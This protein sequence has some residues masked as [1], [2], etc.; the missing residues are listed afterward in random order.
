MELKEKIT[1]LN[2]WLKKTYVARC[3]G[4]APSTYGNKLVNNIISNSKSTYICSRFNDADASRL[5][6]W[7]PRLADELSTIHIEWSDDRNKVIDQIRSLKPMF[8]LH[9]ISEQY[10]GM[11]RRKFL[12]RCVKHSDK[13]AN[14][15]F[16]Q[17]DIDRINAAI[18]DF[19]TIVSGMIAQ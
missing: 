5:E 10:V 4:M 13:F 14:S 16:N 15:S 7:L 3:M 17:R 18:S 12:V 11:E 2:I 8:N 9:Y 19:T 1:I 6:E